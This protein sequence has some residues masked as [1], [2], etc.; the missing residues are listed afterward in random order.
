MKLEAVWLRSRHRI[1]QRGDSVLSEPCPDNPRPMRPGARTVY[2]I[3][4][5]AGRPGPEHGFSWASAQ[6]QIGGG[7]PT[8][9]VDLVE[10]TDHDD[11]ADIAVQFNC[12]VR[13]ITHQP[14]AEG[15]ELRIQLKPQGDC[16]MS[17]ASQT[18]GELPPLSGGT[19]IINNVRVDSDVPGPADPCL[20]FP[21]TGALCDSARG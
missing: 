15:K 21:Q 12:S 9:I 1:D 11:Q 19:N 7:A 2:R 14:A 20:Q 6:A 4:A 10:L 16:G 18:I 8:R 3:V 5:A 13:Y 17:L